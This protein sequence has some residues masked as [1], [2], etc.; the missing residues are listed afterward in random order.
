MLNWCCKRRIRGQFE[1]MIREA[2]DQICAAVEAEDGEGTFREDAW[3]RPGGGGGVSRVM[4]VRKGQQGLMN[5]ASLDLGCA[6][7][8]VPVCI[9]L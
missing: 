6:G 2:Q 1:R 3:C 7:M 8:P 9:R 4:Q 5:I